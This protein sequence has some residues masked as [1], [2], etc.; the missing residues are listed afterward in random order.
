[1]TSARKLD[2]EYTESLLNLK[3]SKRGCRHVLG[4]IQNLI[5]QLGHERSRESGNKNRTTVSGRTNK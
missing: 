2:T 4:S 3:G 5:G 1:M